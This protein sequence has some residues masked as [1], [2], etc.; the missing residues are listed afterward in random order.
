MNQ[1]DSF[2]KNTKEYKPLHSPVIVN[3]HVKPM[4]VILPVIVIVLVIMVMTIYSFVQR[5]STISYAEQVTNQMAEY[6]AVNISNEIDYAKS[7]IKLV[8]L[9]VSQTMHS[10]TLNNPK[11]TI[12]PMVKNTPFGSIEYIRAD[13]MNVMNIGEPFDASDRVYY[14]EG[15][16]GNTGIWNNYHPKTSKETLINFYTP[17]VYEDNVVGVMTGYIQATAQLSPLFEKSLYGQEVYSILVDENNM[18]ICSTIEN[19]YAPDMTFDMLCDSM[20][21][22]ENLKLSMAEIISNATEKAESY[23]EPKGRGR[24]C[25][26]KIPGTEWTFIV[27]VPEKSFNAIISDD[28]RYSIEAVVVIALILMTYAAYVLI[29]NVKRRK[30]IAIENEKLEEENH[31]FDEANKKAFNEISEIRDIIAS[32]NMGTWRIELVDGQEPKMFADGTMKKLLGI[33]EEDY[34]PEE[35]YK[36]WYER[37]KPE[38]LDSVLRSVDIMTNGN[39]DENTYL[40][41]HP[42]KGERYVRCG[43]TSHK[44]EGGI[45]LR[46]Y[47]Y[48][49]DDVVREDLAKVVMLRDALNE[50]NDYYTTLGTLGGIFNS[51][52]VI[53]LEKDTTTEFYAEKEV[54][55][56]VNHKNGAR[57]MMTH[58]MRVLITD[59][60]LQ[61]ALEYTDLNTVADRLQGKKLITMQL[62]GKNIGWFIASFITM[63]TDENGKPTRV[64]FTTRSIDEEKKQE[65]RLISRAQTDELT[66][67]LNRRAYE[68]DIYEHNDVPSEEHFVY[69]SLDVNGLKV[70]NDTLG[71]AAGDELLIGASDCMKRSLGAYGKVYRVGGDEFVAVLFCDDDKLKDVFT[72]FDDAILNWSGKLVEELTISYGFVSKEE[73]PNLSVRQMGVIADQRMY[74]AKTNHYKKTGVDRRGQK[75]AHK[76]L[77]ELY[78]KILK[79][80]I[81]DDTFQVVNMDEAEQTKNLGYSDKISEWLIMFGK[82]GRVH[83][84]DLQDYFEHTSMDYM[85][86]YFADNKT[87][88]N[89][90]YRRKYGDEY[91]QVMMEM[92]PANDYSPENQTLFLYVKNIDK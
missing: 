43:G 25:V 84:D 49:V 86:E 28:T 60:Y 40:W 70:V 77:C 33:Q 7:S 75:D 18:V 74:E 91:K 83:P 19:D 90:F 12:I 41:L 81:T 92:I 21:I 57:E 29:K 66:G 39:Y 68:E 56:I 71:H 8:S 61:K 52:H 13:G 87:S 35:V 82:T 17:L 2:R 80:N 16:Q 72:D 32:A 37:I 15:I 78:T 51:M 73:Q 63:D 30:A 24:I 11:D 20:K 76:A 23:K 46:G 79:I 6:V 45:A 89:V 27:L 64:V 9:N 59:E 3:D 34:S 31:L 53:D 26:A 67:L 85:R 88:L 36:A 55:Q 44:I 58:V 5:A 48:D 54:K 38:A 4:G 42:T 10:D 1:N 22:D 50:K 69:V 14:K 62:I 47:H 65:E